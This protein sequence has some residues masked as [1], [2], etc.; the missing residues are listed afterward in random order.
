MDW[1]VEQCKYLAFENSAFQAKEILRISLR[2]DLDLLSQ[3]QHLFNPKLFHNK[4]MTNIE[5]HRTGPYFSILFFRSAS[6]SL[7]FIKIEN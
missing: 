7:K 6:D 4:P 1:A 5:K 3:F 2:Y